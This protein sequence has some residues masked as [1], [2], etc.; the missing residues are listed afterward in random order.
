[1]VQLYRREMALAAQ[2]RK[3]GGGLMEESGM[4]DREPS[5]RADQIQMAL[6]NLS[7]YFC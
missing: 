3:G 6:Q 2:G 4:R 7:Y 5:L 1:M